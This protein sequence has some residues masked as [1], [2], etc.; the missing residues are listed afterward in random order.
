[1]HIA[2]ISAVAAAMTALA[3]AA[4]Q[5]GV[6]V[7]VNAGGASPAD[8]GA[9]VYAPSGAIFGEGAVVTTAAVAAPGGSDSIEGEF[10][11][12]PAV[13]ISGAIGYDF[14]L[15][16]AEAEV[17]YSRHSV[18]ALNVTQLTGFGGSTTTDLQDGA[19]DACAYLGVDTC[20]ASGNSIAYSGQKIRQL[21]GMANV[22]VDLP[23]GWPIEPYVGGGIG[24][25]GL[26]N[27]GEARSAFAWQIGGGLAYKLA[28]GLALTAD[29][30]YRSVN[31]IKFDFGGGEGLNFGRLKTTTY[32]VGLRYSF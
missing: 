7:S 6:Y 12:K 26:E 32:G 16:R 19:S 15:V 5:A 14:G 30:R 11:L 10:D 9:V 25:V 8:V 2:K 1:M 3:P 20:P 29:V 28:G 17:A 23:I 24:V 4:A 13:Q 22:W 31:E 21:A 18:Q 27:D